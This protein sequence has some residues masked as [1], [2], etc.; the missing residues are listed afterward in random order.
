MLQPSLFRPH[1]GVLRIVAIFAC[2][3][4][5]M[6]AGTVFA[7]RVTDLYTAEVDLPAGRDG[8]DQA[9]AQALA[10]VVVK[11]SGQPAAAMSE[12]L[13]R[14]GDPARLVQQYRN[15]AAGRLVVGFDPV[16]LRQAMDRAALP[17][18]G[19]ERPATLVWL[20]IDSG[21]GRR[22]IVSALDDA[23]GG[24]MDRGNGDLQTIARDALSQ[25]ARARGLPLI[26]P[27]VDG[28]DLQVTS[29]ADL[30][31]DFTAPVLEASRRYRADAVLIGRARGTDPA[32][33]GVR[34]TLLMGDQRMDW[35]GTIASGPRDAADRLALQQAVSIDQRQDLRVAVAG[36]D[37]LADYANITRYLSELSTVDLCE[38]IQVEGDRVLFRLSVRG[39]PDQLMRTIALRRLLRP[40]EPGLDGGLAD[41]Y[42]AVIAD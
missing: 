29:F 35:N 42:Y 12:S 6:Q 40:L 28:E 32:T 13:E 41:L 39:S 8:L 5:A 15:A 24:P 1:L 22:E 7:A 21:R 2:L 11:L 37:S 19:D 26:L 4:L 34:W 30:W 38:V 20:A 9:F 33:T 27:L 23:G 16:A 3:G 36:V 31:G 10:E 25:S 14:L 18:W 17:I